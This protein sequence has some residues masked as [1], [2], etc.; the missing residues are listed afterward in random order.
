VDR[1]CVTIKIVNE[2][3]TAARDHPKV[4]TISGTKSVQE[5]WMFAT[6]IIHTT[7]MAS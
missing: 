7:P 4:F 6:A 5:Y 1:T 2:L 3:C